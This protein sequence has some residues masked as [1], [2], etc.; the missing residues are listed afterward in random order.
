MPEIKPGNFLESE[1]QVNLN[2]CLESNLPAVFSPQ[3]GKK[4][5]RG[6]RGIPTP[7]S[8]SRPFRKRGKVGAHP[9]QRGVFH[10][11]LTEEEIDVLLVF[12]SVNKMRFCREK[13]AMKNTT[14]LGQ[15]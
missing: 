12:Q 7:Q 4:I 15:G 1:D 3:T 5:E 10:G 2:K 14:N 9:A 6:K 13:T 11:D 8:F